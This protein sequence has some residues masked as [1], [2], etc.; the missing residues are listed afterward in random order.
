M[1]STNEYENRVVFFFDILGFRELVN[2]NVYENGSNSSSILEMFEFINDFYKDEIDE[3]Y[4]ASKHI[5]FFSDS[6]IISFVEDEPDQV[7]QTVAD[8]QILLLNLILRGVVMRGAISYGKLFHSDKFLFGPAFISA[9][10]I[11]RTKAK[12]PRIICDDSI[13][14]LSQRGKT[15]HSA[16][17]DLNIFLEIVKP[18]DDNFWYIDY[19]EGIESLFDDNYEHIN[20]LFKLRHLIVDNIHKA[21]SDNV[22]DKY[23]WMKEKYNDAVE[24]ILSNKD[25]KTMQDYEI[26]SYI[27][28]LTLI[29]DN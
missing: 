24:D 10:D 7:F 9:Y 23:L 3:R 18:D 11:E 20:Y 4:S 12:V 26:K 16:Q 8:I 13:V 15:L 19:F 6:V 27:E 17:Q 25:S 2:S 1:E 21:K 5:T 14:L 28:Q 22:K 29:D